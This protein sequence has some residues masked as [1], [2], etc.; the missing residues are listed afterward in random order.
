VSFRSQ[1]GRSLAQPARKGGRRGDRGFWQEKGH[2]PG[3]L[4]AV[5]GEA[6]VGQDG[7]LTRRP[8]EGASLCLGAK[9]RRPYY[10]RPHAGET[11][12]RGGRIVAKKLVL[13]LVLISSLWMGC[14]SLIVRPYDSGSKKAA[15]IS[16]RVV[17]GAATLAY[18]ELFVW[19]AK[20]IEA[21]AWA[22]ESER[23]YV[24]SLRDC[25]DGSLSA[26]SADP[27]DREVHLA[28]HDQ[29]A[30]ELRVHMQTKSEQA[31]AATRAQAA[32]L[33]NIGR[34]FRQKQSTS[35]RSTAIG[36]TVYTNC[37]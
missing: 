24:R 29:C 3:L 11:F 35:C 16:T 28:R 14:A 6:P 5:V 4:T 8:R 9:A 12:W 13:P 30:S 18:S 7:P 10:R 27:T 15:K 31:A 36:N 33:Q 19:N 20:R 26:A 25:M 17:L 32:A 37:N 2:D 22:R 21:D 1:N 23:Q 34:S